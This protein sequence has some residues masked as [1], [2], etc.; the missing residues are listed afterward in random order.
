MILAVRNSKLVRQGLFS[1]LVK[2]Q[3]ICGTSP[4]PESPF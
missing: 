2:F 4:V 1:E 3:L